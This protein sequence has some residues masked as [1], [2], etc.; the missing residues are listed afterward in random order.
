[1]K[2]QQKSSSR[3]GRMIKTF[4]RYWSISVVWEVFVVSCLSLIPLL[5]IGFVS[6][7]NDGKETGL[8]TAILEPLGRGQ[9]YLYSF[10][11]LAS[12]VWIVI[13]DLGPTARKIIGPISVLLL[14]YVI[15][16]LGISPEMNNLGNKVILSY[17]VYVYAAS[18][19]LYL[20]SL[21]IKGAKPP[22][23]EEVFMDGVNTLR[24]QVSNLQ[25]QQASE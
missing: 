17:S 19:L 2:L 23:P 12:V 21:L 20:F 22:L 7:V 14:V 16:L 15:L 4:Q 11:V 13:S 9:L 10:S 1:M 8:L 18:I 3:L 25:A 6:F 5:A 24:D